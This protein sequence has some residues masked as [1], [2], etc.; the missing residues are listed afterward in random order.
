MMFSIPLKLT[1]LRVVA[2][3]LRRELRTVAMTD[4]DIKNKPQ[5]LAQPATAFMSFMSG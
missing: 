1:L 5:L 3:A 2:A 4:K